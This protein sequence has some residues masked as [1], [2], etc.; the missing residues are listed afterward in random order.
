MIR[1]KFLLFLPVLVLCSADAYASPACTTNTFAYY[2]T[3]P[4]SIGLVNFDFSVIGG[5]YQFTPDD[6]NPA[7]ADVTVTPVGTGLIA[8]QQVGFTFG[9]NNFVVNPPAGTPGYNRNTDPFGG[10][11]TCCVAG[12]AANPTGTGWVSTNP[13]VSG[14]GF[15]DLN[16]T[17]S[18]SINAAHMAL[19]STTTQLGVFIYSPDG[20][21]T[22]VQGGETVTD[23]SSKAQ[24]GSLPFYVDHTGTPT[25]STAFSQ[26]ATSLNVNK[27]ISIQAV[28]ANTTPNSA[29]LNSVT[30]TF[31]FGDTS[32]PEPGSFVLIGLTALLFAAYS[33]R[34]HLCALFAL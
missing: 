32:V 7:A 28:F 11:P 13:D 17:F 29:A 5:A 10:S 21:G 3:H 1:N 25:T 8:G 27:D 16:I 33:W 6:Y 12:S 9:N 20:G 31:T 26:P 15:A 34:K 30:E 19:N 14:N 23:A 4:C 24:I 18:V 2:E 22:V